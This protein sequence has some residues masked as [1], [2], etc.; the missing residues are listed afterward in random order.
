MIA[1]EEVQQHAEAA[2]EWGEIMEEVA[3]ERG[4]LLAEARQEGTKARGELRALRTKQ[5]ATQAQL[6]DCEAEV[7]AAAVAAGHMRDM[8]R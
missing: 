3:E 7:A 4:A 2:E 1:Q 5:H 8:V 6:E